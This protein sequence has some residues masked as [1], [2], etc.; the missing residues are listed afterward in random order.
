M[1]RRHSGTS[2]PQ[3]RQ[4][5]P[6]SLPAPRCWQS[7]PHALRRNGI[8]AILFA[9]QTGSSMPRISIRSVEALSEMT[10]EVVRMKL[11]LLSQ[12]EGEHIRR[13]P[14]RMTVATPSRSWHVLPHGDTSLGIPDIQS[15][16]EDGLQ[17]GRG[18]DQHQSTRPEESNGRGAKNAAHNMTT[19]VNVNNHF[20]GS[21]PRSIARLL[22]VL[23]RE[24]G[25]P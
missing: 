24:A 18:R 2:V 22:E 14:S 25:K 9:V 8:H 19:F 20:E 21:A 1:A 3:I 15:R 6:S 11:D 12:E 5:Y 23:A 17:K 7:M 10:P 4:L 13:M 16:G